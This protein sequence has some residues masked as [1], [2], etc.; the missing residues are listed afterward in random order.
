MDAQT[1]HKFTHMNT[2][3]TVRPTDHQK[4]KNKVL[5]IKNML[6]YTYKQLYTY[7]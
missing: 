5:Y 2:K 1:R 3:E 7:T 4:P 6:Y